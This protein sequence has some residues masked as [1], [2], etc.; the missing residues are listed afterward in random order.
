VRE[1]DLVAGKLDRGMSKGDEGRDN[2]VGVGRNRKRATQVA[3][4]KGNELIGGEPSL[5]VPRA[6]KEKWCDQQEQ[7]V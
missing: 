5:R 6:L 4:N 3:L 1:I 2:W 7:E